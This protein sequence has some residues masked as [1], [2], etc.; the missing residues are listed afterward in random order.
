[1]RKSN[2]QIM[3][4]LHAYPVHKKID[5]VQ[6]GRRH[7]VYLTTSKEEK[8]KKDAFIFVHGSPGS[9]D[10]FMYYMH[11]EDLLAA[12]DIIS[13]DRPGFGHSDYGTALPSLRGQ[14]SI[15]FE[16]MK[17]LDYDR[18]WLVGHSYGG[19]VLIQAVIDRPDNIGGIAIIAG[20]IVY[21][22]EPV[23]AWRKWIDLPFVR[24]L[25]PTSF[26]VSND[27][28]MALRRDLR[29]IDDDWDDIR[30]PVTII[31]GTRD[32]LV[33]FENLVMAK[34]KLVNVDSVR[35]QI[36]EGENHFIL[37]TQRNQIANEI[38]ALKNSTTK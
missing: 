12:G 14:A 23:A 32:V 35:T 22:M 38:L 18:Y 13:Y 27:E 20:S 33:P 8:K 1:M 36:F 30:T 19:A 5:S 34:E 29:M 2:D 4:A 21:A 9:L 7:I 28:L 11:N 25:L 15:L 24:V 26:R 17:H 37:W 6:I 10:A 3:G 16:L 31:H